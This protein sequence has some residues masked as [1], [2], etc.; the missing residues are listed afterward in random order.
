[1]KRILQI[2]VKK[3]GL[4]ALFLVVLQSISF[5]GLA[6]S[7]LRQDVEVKPGKKT[8]LSITLGNNK[9]SEQTQPCQISLEVLDF[10]ICENGIISFG[11][12]YAHSRSA[13]NW[14]KF[15]DNEVILQPGET[16]EIKATV[17]APINADGD[18][19]AAV[20]IK[21]VKSPDQKG[22]SVNFQTASGIFI[23]AARRNYSERGRIVD[24]NIILPEFAF[25]NNLNEEKAGPVDVNNKEPLLEVKAKL[26]NDGLIGFIA[27]GKAY[28]YNEKNRRIG[29]IQL[30]ATRKQV[31]PGDSRW[32]DGLLAQPLP[33]GEYKFRIF[34]DYSP[35]YNRQIT[36]EVKISISEDMAKTWNEKFVTDNKTKLDIKPEQIELS[37]AP[38]RLTA[39]NFQVENMSLATIAG[40][41]K[42]QC[43]GNYGEWLEL[44]SKDFTLAPAT[45][46]SV[47]CVIRIPAD[48]K[49]GQY[50]W[51]I[52]VEMEKSGLIDKSNIERYQIPVKVV[53]GELA[54]AI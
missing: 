19:W 22:V 37:L 21:Q 25:N 2:N 9:R 28:I 50:D 12:E 6:V 17:T 20:M 35:K 26:Q 51:T 38:K 7:P 18:Y 40:S 23:H 30:H 29:T 4:I 33:A 11:K 48:A 27:R 52:F 46:R 31:L 1:M 41:C 5:A 3:A 39:T 14:I 10:K 54:C 32:F 13:V 45:R 53:V 8:T 43:Q 34:F 49:A 24:A 16:K 15:E 47:T 42:V 44:K 36:K